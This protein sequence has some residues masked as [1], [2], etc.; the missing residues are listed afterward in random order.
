[1][2]KTAPDSAAWQQEADE[3]GINTVVFGLA[4]YWGLGTAPLAKFCT[5]QTWKPV[6]LDDVAVIFVRNTPAN[7]EVINRLEIDC[8][9]A[10]LGTPGNLGF[11]G[12]P[13]GR[14]ELFNYYA[15]A[16][17]VLYK[18]SRNAEAEVMLDRALQMFPEEP[19]LHHTRGQVYEASGR[20]EDAER[21]YRTSA[22]LNPTDANWYSLSLLYYSQH[23]YAEAV[24]AAKKAAELSDRPGQYYVLLGT[25]RLANR[26]PQDAL[27]AFDAASQ[28]AE[29]SPP[30]ARAVIES[31]VA[32]GRAEAWARLG[33]L[34]RAI[35]FQQEA[36]E[37]APGNAQLWITLAELY[38]A[39]GRVSL[40]QEA[41]QHAQSLSAPSQ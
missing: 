20:L 36:L 21:E 25:L 13:R 33:N 7:A 2:L 6:Y 14:A 1:L 28:A 16:G 15:N 19:F 5:S 12:F 18:L 27:E 30:D 40:E 17:S 32:S 31:S 23:R 8:G 38:R 3:R 11:S 4:R 39:Q 24:G 22:Q 26:Q 41:R 37:M 29:Y 10:K 9:K 35:G 34:R